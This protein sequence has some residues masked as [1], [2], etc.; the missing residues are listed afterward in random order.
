MNGAL[1]T[2]HK[3]MG[4]EAGLTMGNENYLNQNN[5]NNKSS[6][7]LGYGGQSF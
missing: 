6:L 2:P 4:K 3:A 7:K 5:G 1:N